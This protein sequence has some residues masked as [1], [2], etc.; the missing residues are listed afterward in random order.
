MRDRFK[1]RFDPNRVG[2]AKVLG[3]LEALVMGILWDRGPSTVGDVHAALK[4]RREIAY[5]TVLTILSRLKEKGLLER[6]LVGNSHLYSPTM[7]R[8]EFTGRVVERIVDGLLD[9]FSQPA[10]AY[11]MRRLGQQDDTLLKELEKLLAERA[12]EQG[13]R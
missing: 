11:F 3:P 5:T 8:E 1:F 2:M 6:T 4:G 10:L 7:T 12:K 9:A 13:D